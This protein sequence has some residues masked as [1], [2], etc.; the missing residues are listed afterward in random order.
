[1][2]DMVAGAQGY[3]I[4]KCCR[5]FELPDGLEVTAGAEVYRGMLD[6]GWS[7][8][9][10]QALYLQLVRW[11]QESQHSPGLVSSIVGKLDF[12]PAPKDDLTDS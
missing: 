7:T 2:L 1:M 8:D 5:G 9:E 6:E 4:A 3:M 10:I 11:V 12:S